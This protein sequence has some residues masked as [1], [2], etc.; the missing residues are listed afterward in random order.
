[1]NLFYDQEDSTEK[2]QPSAIKAAPSLQLQVEVVVVL[3]KEDGKS[4]SSVGRNKDAPPVRVV[5]NK[6]SGQ[7]VKRS[8]GE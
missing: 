7:R 8:R 3:E 6:R 1:M 4:R 5:E 2:W